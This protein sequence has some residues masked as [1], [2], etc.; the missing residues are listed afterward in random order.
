MQDTNTLVHL[1][2]TLDAM[3]IPDQHENV[4]HES[5]EYVR[6]IVDCANKV[7]IDE[8]GKNI[9]ENHAVLETYGFSVFPGEVDRY[10]WL[11]GC[12]QTKKGIVV[13]G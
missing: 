10:G 12:I 5:V 7:L 13:Y 4:L 1:L 2:E 9:W 6:S 11:S 3:E 8:N